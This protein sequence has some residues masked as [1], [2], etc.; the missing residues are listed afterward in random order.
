MQASPQ[1]PLCG[2]REPCTLDH[3]LP[4]AVFPLLSVMPVNL[5]PACTECNKSKSAV[6]ATTA[7]GQTLHPYF[8]NVDHDLWL[9]AEVE[10]RT[11]PALVFSADPPSHWPP[12]L[13]DRIRHHFVTFKL[14]RLYGSQASTELR[15]I[16]YELKLVSDAGGGS[17][18]R[19]HLQVRAQSWSRGVGKANHW[20]TAAYRALA[21]N[22]WYCSGGFSQG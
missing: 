7:A 20:K 9:K 13:S 1:C 6:T 10:E 21:A 17:A 2:H 16:E 11:P 19:S 12:V 5:V 18:V 22:S 3:Y 15:G 8:D 14:A 4:K